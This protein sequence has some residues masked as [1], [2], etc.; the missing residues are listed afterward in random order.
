M[1]ILAGSL[2][3]LKLSSAVERSVTQR[4]PIAINRT[5]RDWRNRLILFDAVDVNT[6]VE[7]ELHGR[8]VALPLCIRAANKRTVGDMH[9]EIRAAQANLLHRRA[10]G[11]RWFARLPRFARDVF[12]WAIFKHPQW[13]KLHFIIVF[14]L[15]GWGLGRKPHALRRWRKETDRELPRS[16]HS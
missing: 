7:L 2:S 14:R 3:P 15:R 12:Y 8:K 11:M 6:M 5:Y 10:F 13:L 1:L 16:V 9:A 4:R